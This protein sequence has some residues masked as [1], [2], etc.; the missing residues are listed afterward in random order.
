MYANSRYGREQKGGKR[1][2]T[3]FGCS[4]DFENLRSL[5]PLQTFSI[6][7]ILNDIP[8]SLAMTATSQLTPSLQEVTKALL[9]DGSQPPQGNTI[10]VY[11]SIAADVI[12]PVAAF[13][14]MTNGA[15][16]TK[17]SFLCES[18]TGGEKIGRYSFVGTSE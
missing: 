17:R 7:T 15:D 13:L 4:F 8:K 2:S 3:T 9:G 18:V 16:K 11:A 5:T 1:P 14:R 12:T 6:H 10:P